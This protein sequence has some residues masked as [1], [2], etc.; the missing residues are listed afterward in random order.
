M[1]ENWGASM[2]YT[3]CP[4]ALYCGQLRPNFVPS[5]I[6]FPA[7]VFGIGGSQRRELTG[8]SAN[9]IPRYWTTPAAVVSSMNPLTVPTVVCI[10]RPDE[11]VRECVRESHIGI[12]KFA[13]NM[14]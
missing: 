5:I 11:D 1:I 9:G 2:A 12:N 10:D 6:V 4:A 3:L 7:Y 14:M 13:G 8:G